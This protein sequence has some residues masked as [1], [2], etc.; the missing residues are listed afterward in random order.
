MKETN[1]FSRIERFLNC[2]NVRNSGYCDY[3]DDGCIQVILNNNNNNKVDIYRMYNIDRCLWD[4][5]L[6]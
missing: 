6:P 4:F 3:G 1:I 5:L 2:W